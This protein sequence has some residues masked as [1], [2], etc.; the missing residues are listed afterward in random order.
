VL[1]FLNEG[2]GVRLRSGLLSKAM[3]RVL[4]LEK[5]LVVTSHSSK[6]TSEFHLGV[7]APEKK[8]GCLPFEGPEMYGF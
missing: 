2:P 1:Y 6:G 3:R 4:E 5:T 8:R 7:A